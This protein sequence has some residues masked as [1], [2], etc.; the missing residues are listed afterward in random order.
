M[1][2]YML[3]LKFNE[4]M[5]RTVI[6]PA[7][8]EQDAYAILLCELLPSMSQDQYPEITCECVGEV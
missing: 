5:I 7:E 6:I 1:F 2:E 8:C 3:T 4:E